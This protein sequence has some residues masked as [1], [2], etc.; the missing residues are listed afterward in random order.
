[1]NIEGLKKAIIPLIDAIYASIS[2]TKVSEASAAVAKSNFIHASKRLFRAVELLKNVDGRETDALNVGPIFDDWEK[3][4]PLLIQEERPKT[5][6]M[7]DALPGSRERASFEQ[8]AIHL[9]HLAAITSM[10]AS[11]QEIKAVVA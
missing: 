10:I 3:L 6:E 1:M 2:K 8:L 9:T 11:M 5:A 7:I 4:K